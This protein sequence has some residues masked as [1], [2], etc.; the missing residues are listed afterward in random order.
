MEEN[1]NKKEKDRVERLIAILCRCEKLKSSVTNEPVS[2]HTQRRSTGKTKQKKKE[3]KEIRRKGTKKKDDRGKNFLFNSHPSI[4]FDLC[5]GGMCLFELVHAQ[6]QQRL[7][8]PTAHTGTTSDVIKRESFLLSSPVSYSSFVPN[9]R[10][11]VGERERKRK[12]LDTP[13]QSFSVS[14]GTTKSNLGVCCS[15]TQQFAGRLHID[16]I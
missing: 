15:G 6:Q 3:K 14:V 7:P 5:I 2:C 11:R 13:I 8:I 4:T 1:N 9:R 16:G 12:R 10:Q